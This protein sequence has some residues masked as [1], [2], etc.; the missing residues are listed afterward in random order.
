MQSAQTT[1][2]DAC[3]LIS[4]CTP[5]MGSAAW[6]RPRAKEPAIAIFVTYDPPENVS[7]GMSDA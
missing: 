1:L 4:A 2:V 7:S 3:A 6:N 5:N